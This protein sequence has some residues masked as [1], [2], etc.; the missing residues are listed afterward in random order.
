M[1]KNKE[2]I[3]FYLSEEGK[4]LAERISVFLE[5]A[6]IYKFDR[7]TKRDIKRH[8]KPEKVLIF[9]MA[10]G[11][12]ARVCAGFIKNKDH[13]PGIIVI[14]ESGNNVIAYLGGHY[15]DI[16]RITLE[17]ASFLEAHPVITTA[18][19][20]RGLP[21]LDNWIKELGFFIKNKDQLYVIMSKFNEKGNLKV[22]LEEGLNYPLSSKLERVFTPEEA[23][24]VVS[25]KKQELENK[26]I[27]IPRCLYAGIGFHE[28]LTEEDFEELLKST[29]EELS[30]EF[31]AL[32]GI[33][34]LDKKAE[35]LPLKNFVLREGLDL[36][37]FRKD[38]LSEVEVISPSQSAKKALGIESVSEACALL[39]SKGV[40]LY[41]KRIYK[42]F[43]IALALKP[44]QKVGKLYVVGIGPGSRDYLTLKALRVLTNVSAVVGY[45]SYIKQILPL[46]KTKEVYDFSMTQ[47]ID[48]V[49]KAIELA[50]AGK[51][52]AL[53]SGGDPGIY[54]MSGLVLE[55]LHKNKFSLE[56]EIIPGISALN[57]G[58][59]LLGA[60]LGNDFAVISLSDRLT[61]WEVIEERLKRLSEIE[62][63]LVIYN[64]R[65]KGRKIQFERA[66]QILRENKSPNTAVAIVNSASREGEEIIF[67][68]LEKLSS[69]KIGMN[70]LIIVGSKY[71]QFLGKFLIAKRGYERKYGGKYE[72]SSPYL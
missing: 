55:I 49:K 20:N 41:P 42:D 37:G 26:L 64:P 61:P 10:L 47:E 44:F 13:D 25:Y 24:I 50:L 68:T 52:T 56:V 38:E 12:V 29:F 31:K 69:E 62:I 30:L 51:D 66:L 2:F 67:S 40:L 45:K 59:A 63:P 36:N 70:S 27:L 32:K 18:S 22:Y 1:E 17:I 9:I 72:I 43:T 33:A 14:D 28:I 4:A 58:N 53:V 39:V 6:E 16:N 48:R 57:M 60:P 54:G 65:S 5:K 35:Y 7:E 15:A 71:T 34:T 3:I 19:D 21:P 46:I 23:D 8:F 11:I